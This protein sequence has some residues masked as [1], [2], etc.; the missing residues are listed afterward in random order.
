MLSETQVFEYHT[1]TQMCKAFIVYRAVAC[2]WA[3]SDGVYLSHSQHFLTL[4][5][6]SLLGFPSFYSTCNFTEREGLFITIP[7]WSFLCWLH[8]CDAS[9]FSDVVHPMPTWPASLSLL[10]SWG[11][12]LLYSVS[13]C[14]HD[15]LQ[16][17]LPISIPLLCMMSLPFVFF[18]KSSFLTLS[19]LVT[20]SYN[21]PLRCSFCDSKFLFQLLSCCPGFCPVG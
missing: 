20:R 3:V 9:K 1:S 14:C 8:P 4:F 7:P 12:F 18:C 6:H 10:C 21:D 13:I 11:P 15:A 17:G 5:S 16:G 19:F 2:S